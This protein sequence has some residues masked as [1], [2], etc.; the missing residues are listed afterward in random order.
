MGKSALLE[1]INRKYGYSISFDLYEQRHNFCRDIVQGKCSDNDCPIY[2]KYET[3][4]LSCNGVL[5]KYPDECRALM[6]EN[7]VSA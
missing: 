5:N 7:S 4:G 6:T 1:K 2:R 3:S